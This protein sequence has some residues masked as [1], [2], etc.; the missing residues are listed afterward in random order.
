MFIY[1]LRTVSPI[2]ALHSPLNFVRV[3]YLGNVKLTTCDFLVNLILYLCGNM[4]WQNLPICCPNGD[5]TITFALF[6]GI[7]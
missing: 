6:S 2:N 1:L 7:T 3:H 4:F 5:F